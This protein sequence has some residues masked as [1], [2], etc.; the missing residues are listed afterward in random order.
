LFLETGVLMKK[1]NPLVFS[2]CAL[3]F[4]GAILLSA[5][6][7]TPR[8]PS[9]ADNSH[10]LPAQPVGAHDLLSIAVYDA[11]E[12]SRTVR[13]PMLQQRVKVQGLMPS[14][15]ES[16]I[17]DALRSEE[18]LV[19]PFVTVNVVE[20]QSRPI[21]VAGAVRNPTTFQAT[22][23]VSLLEAITRA[24]G[25]TPN[26]GADILVSARQPGPDGG[27]ITL[28]QRVP[29]KKLIDEA[30]AKL[31]VQLRGGEEVR[32]PEVGKLYVVGAVKRPGAYP[33]HDNAGSSVLKALAMSEGLGDFYSKIAYIYRQDDSGT[34]NE[35]SIPFK[36]IM[37][38]KSPDIPLLED[39]ILYVPVNEAGRT[40]ASVIK[41]LTGFGVATASGSIIWGLVR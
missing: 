25:L 5:Q 3:C 28:T 31:N 41:V 40:R 16:A 6:T 14:E 2:L 37:A 26:A 23:S 39:D 34:K 10:N 19:D 21:S 33:I 4:C 17:A 12:F 8:S 38:R 35:I 32:V 27:Q 22:Q 9:P 11:P 29:V 13:L 18:L 24:G 7:S 15:C 1:F 30:D 20:Y 36:D